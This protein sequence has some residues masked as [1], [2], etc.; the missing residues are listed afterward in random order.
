MASRVFISY[1]RQDEPEAARRIRD[2]LTVRF[3]P[4]HVFMDVES[5]LPGRPFEEGLASALDSSDVFLVV[6]GPRWTELLA[7]RGKQGSGTDFVQQEISGALRKKLIIVPVRV[8]HQAGMAPL[9]PAETLPPDIRDLVRYQT[10]DVCYETLG[11]DTQALTEAIVRLRADAN[12]KRR[13]AG[14]MVSQWTA[15]AILAVVVAGLLA[16]TAGTVEVIKFSGVAANLSGLLNLATAPDFRL[17]E[18]FL[19][20]IARTFAIALWGLASATAISLPLATIGAGNMVSSWIAWPVRQV[21]GVFE[22]ADVAIIGVFMLLLFGLSPASAVAAICIWMTGKLCRLFAELIEAADR[23]IEGVRF[24]R[25]SRSQT[26]YAVLPEVL[27]Q[28]I[29]TTVLECSSAVRAAVVLGM[30]GAGGGIGERLL[31]STMMFD[32]GSAVLGLAL[33]LV[34][35]LATQVAARLIAR[36]LGHQ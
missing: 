23:P 17:V 34:A 25:A 7:E 10:Q 36:L 31:K 14:A 18:G 15:M 4:R 27:P 30:L 16:T 13:S 19:S 2:A 3:G 26:A 22:A 32:L 20:D 11:R 9:P 12:R 21:A 6:I 33:L 28:A 8:G 35:V 1:R 29:A 5:L 24:A